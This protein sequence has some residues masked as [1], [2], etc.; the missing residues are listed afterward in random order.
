MDLCDV[1]ES[2]PEI[3]SIEFCFR[4][5]RVPVQLLFNYLE[6]NDLVGFRVGFPSVTEEM[7]HVVLGTS[8][9][10]IIN[11]PLAT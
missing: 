10:A 2:N 3:M 9:K 1:V 8:A 4:G 7:F 11:Q 6:E 5:T